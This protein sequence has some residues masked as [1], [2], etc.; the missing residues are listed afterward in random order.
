M[1]NLRKKVSEQKIKIY[2]IIKKR[3]EKGENHDN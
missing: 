2:T 1:V 3:L